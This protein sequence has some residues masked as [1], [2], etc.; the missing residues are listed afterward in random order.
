LEYARDNSLIK[1]PEKS[2]NNWT[3]Q[4]ILLQLACLYLWPVPPLAGIGRA[5][6]ERKKLV[7]GIRRDLAKIRSRLAKLKE[8]QATLEM[9]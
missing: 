9:Y 7:I 2:E 1:V 8:L 6:K 3:H 4:M 5:W